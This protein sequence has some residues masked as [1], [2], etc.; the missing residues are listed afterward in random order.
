M[1]QVSTKS[2]NCNIKELAF[3][4]LTEELTIPRDTSK[5]ILVEHLENT[6]I[7]LEEGAKLTFIYCGFEGFQDLKKI[8][9]EF[10]GRESELH[11]LGFIIGTKDQTF[12]FETV[13]LHKVPQTK[14]HYNVRATMFD[15]SKVDYKG[16]IIIK[17]SAPLTDAYL[18]HHTLLLS[19]F[20]RA[21]T[22]PALE[23]EADDVKAG[24]AATIGK[25]DEEVMFYLQSRGLPKTEAEL[26]QI[27]GFFEQQL[28][29][30]P[31]EELACSLRE[32]IKSHLP[33]NLNF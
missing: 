23:I 9:F 31:D 8:T 15:H 7:L 17:K 6:H 5:I 24:H 1:T 33:I 19:D 4:K 3:Q 18:A 27:S 28:Q 20:A 16:N 21:R 10:G 11:F 29:Q 14:A 30:V 25:V 2:A 26:L 12:P 32:L 22:I 13:S